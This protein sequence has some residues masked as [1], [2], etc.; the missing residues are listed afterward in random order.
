MTFEQAQL[1]IKLFIMQH[2]DERVCDV[3]P[4]LGN[5]RNLVGEIEPGVDG[6]YWL[7][8]FGY[9]FTIYGDNEKG[10]DY[11]YIAHCNKP[12]NILDY[13]TLEEEKC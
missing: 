9:I 12:F 1:Y 10:V 6:W 2:Y 13:I 3:L 11:R 7:H 8:N 4:N 5:C